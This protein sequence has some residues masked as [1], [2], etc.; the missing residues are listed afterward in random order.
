MPKENDVLKLTNSQKL[1]QN[2]FVTLRKN[3][4]DLQALLD[5]S[6]KHNERL[7][8]IGEKNSQRIK[9]L[10]E[11]IDKLKNETR[12]TSVDI[13]VFVTCTHCGVEVNKSFE[14]YKD[15][16]ISPVIKCPECKRHICAFLLSGMK[17]DFIKKV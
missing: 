11:I 16:N 17:K 15:A 10:N 2:M 5:K 6:L 3:V 4:I 8:I 12:A 9:E 14:F 7:I 1:E 13:T